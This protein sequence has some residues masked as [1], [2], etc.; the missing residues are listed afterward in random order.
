MALPLTVTNVVAHTDTAVINTATNMDFKI[1][2][3]TLYFY[4]FISLVSIY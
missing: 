4:D 3:L 1:F 2:I